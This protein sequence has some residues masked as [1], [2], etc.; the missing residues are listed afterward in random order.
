[1]GEKNCLNYSSL[2]SWLEI[3]E[4][5]WPEKKIDCMRKISND[6][7]SIRKDNTHTLT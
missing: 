5:K 7:T 2:M 3:E 4:R 6:N 1:M